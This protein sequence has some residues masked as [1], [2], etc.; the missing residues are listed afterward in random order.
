MDGWPFL[1]G[2]VSTYDAWEVEGGSPLQFQGGGDVRGRV[3][4]TIQKVY[5][6]QRH[7]VLDDMIGGLCYFSQSTGIYWCCFTLL[8]SFTAPRGNNSQAGMA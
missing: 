8:C 3:V 1:L 6:G 5:G 2:P 4:A 7:K